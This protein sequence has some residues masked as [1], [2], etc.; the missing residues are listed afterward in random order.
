MDEHGVCG[1]LVKHMHSLDVQQLMFP[2]PPAQPSTVYKDPPAR[3]PY[4]CARI[5]RL[6]RA[7]RSEHAKIFIWLLK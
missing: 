6:L 3:S 1:T 7:L 5:T 2:P 4:V